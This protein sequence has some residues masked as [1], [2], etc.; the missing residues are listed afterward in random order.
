MSAIQSAILATLLT[1]LP[2]ERPALTLHA[3]PPLA[4]DG[5]ILGAL[6]AEA[7]D[8]LVAAGVEGVVSGRLKSPESLRAKARRKGLSEDEVLD[9]LALRVR[10]DTE[11]DCYEVLDRLHARFRP[12]PGAQDDYIAYPKAN[13]YQSLHTAVVTTYGVAEFQ[14]RTHA[15]HA[16]AETGG[17]AHARYKRAM[18]A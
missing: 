18:V 13:G 8:L 4:D 7:G 17:A 9:R 15:M 11:V 14:V 12:V 10:V 2:A 1:G 5:W 6:E 16:W 3:P